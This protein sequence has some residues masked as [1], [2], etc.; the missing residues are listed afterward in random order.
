MVFPGCFAGC[1]VVVMIYQALLNAF[2]AGVVF[3]L[4][5]IGIPSR[6]ITVP[7]VALNLL[8]VALLMR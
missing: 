2:C 5:I 6:M 1:G 4:A 3:M 7:T 8:A